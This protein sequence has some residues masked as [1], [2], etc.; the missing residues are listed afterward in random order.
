MR[1][2]L[3]FL[4]LSVLAGACNKTGTSAATP[5]AYSVRLQFADAPGYRYTELTDVS[6]SVDGTPFR[7]ASA[8]AVSGL[9]SFPV[10][11][12]PSVR[13]VD[14]CLGST[15][16]D[17]S[18]SS[19]QTHYATADEDLALGMRAFCRVSDFS[20]NEIRL[21]PVPVTAALRL[22]LYDSHNVAVGEK[23]RSVTLKT[24]VALAGTVSADYAAG[25]F[26]ATPGTSE[27]TVD[28]E[29]SDA[30]RQL[31]V[32]TMIQP[33][34]LGIVTL[35]AHPA[36]VKLTVV[37]DRFTYNF[38]LSGGLELTAGKTVV[39]GLDFSQPDALPQRRIA[40][41][42]D[43][44]STF[45]GYSPSNYGPYY[46]ANDR[47]GTG[48]VQSVDKTYWHQVIYKYSRNSILDSNRSWGGT[49]VVTRPG[50][51]NGF[52]QR[53]TELQDPDLIIIHGGTNDHNYK[54]ELGTYDWDLTIDQ[55]DETKFRS[56]YIKLIRRFNQ[57]YPGAR[58]L[59]VVG[60]FLSAPYA[61]S[62]IEIATHFGI[63]YADF[64]S[65]GTVQNDKVNI[66]KSTGSHPD[67]T[68]HAY[69]ARVIA[70]TLADYL[71]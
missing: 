45:D 59:I 43:S 1:T 26:S 56:A 49:T 27:I 54:S 65:G 62:V 11:L 8:A 14:V 69:M 3:V 37:T 2:R 42:G 39:A 68:G 31:A 44:I 61:L 48:T 29:G 63:P 34:E 33:G 13:T 67:A 17:L 71:P 25:T 47:D 58:L 50:R 57:L 22:M 10:N 9:A 18:V 28:C 55:L 32:G 66:P 64:T 40:V 4:I 21:N 23:I 52:L 36:S 7:K 41:F 16:N 6:Y 5:D 19:R 20:A 53:V 70:E 51:T 12:T 30:A 38:T 35:P 60:D 15:S 24:E 46:P